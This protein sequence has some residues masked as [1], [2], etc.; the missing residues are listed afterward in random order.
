MRAERL[1]R[2]LDVLKREYNNAQQENEAYN[3]YIS[4]TLGVE[5]VGVDN[6]RIYYD[7]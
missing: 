1:Q 7:K 5:R 6:G 4:K 2:E 3:R